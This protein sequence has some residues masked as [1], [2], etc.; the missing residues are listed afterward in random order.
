MKPSKLEI[1]P[2]NGQ[3]LDE[4]AA[5]QDLLN[6]SDSEV[7]QFCNDYSF[8]MLEHLYHMGHKA[9]DYYIKIIINYFEGNESIGDSV[10]VNLIYEACANYLKSSDK[11][12]MLISNLM[13]YILN[14]WK[15]FEMEDDEQSLKD[16][17]ENLAQGK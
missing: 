6:L 1:S 7:Q 17:I 8:A 9:F 12:K 16:A 11:S 15:K 10:G 4:L 3:D 13:S 5:V 14:N 2:T